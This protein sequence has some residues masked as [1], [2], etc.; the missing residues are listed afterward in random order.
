MVKRIDGWMARSKPGQVLYHPYI[1]E[2]GERGPF[3]NADARAGFIGFNASHRFAEML[4][5]V[6][7]G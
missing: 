4:R 2:A 6:I 7:D 5:A 1:S 3:V